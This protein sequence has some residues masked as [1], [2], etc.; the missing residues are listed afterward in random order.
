MLGLRQAVNYMRRPILR[1]QISAVS[2]QRSAVN[3]SMPYMILTGCRTI[4]RTHPYR[5]STS[6]TSCARGRSH[7]THHTRWVYRYPKLAIYVTP[8]AKHLVHLPHR[9]PLRAAR[10]TS[11]T[12][13]ASPSFSHAS[14][15]FSG[16]SITGSVVST[17]APARASARARQAA[18]VTDPSACRARAWRARP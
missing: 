15:S 7:L 3:Y 6:S 8:S 12:P 17:H 11:N 9:R 2:S 4:L 18:R 5:M 13:G 10:F 16:G 14:R 1:S